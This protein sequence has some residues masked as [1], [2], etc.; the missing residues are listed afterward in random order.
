MEVGG[1]E[2]GQEGRVVPGQALYAIACFLYTSDCADHLTRVTRS[3]PSI[4]EESSTNSN[5]Y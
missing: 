5:V 3:V 2:A 1:E 4:H